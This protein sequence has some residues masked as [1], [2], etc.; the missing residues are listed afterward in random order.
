M[1]TTQMFK[2][3]SDY[4]FEDP[5]FNADFE[6]STISSGKEKY[7]L[8]K[9]VVST[10]QSLM[11]MDRDWWEDQ[12][13]KVVIVDEVHTASG[14]SIKSI[15][16]KLIHTKIRIGTTGTLQDAEVHEF[17]LT[18]LFGEPKQIIKTADLMET[19]Q[20]S[21]LNI[22]CLI[23]QYSKDTKNLARD[24][25]YQDEIDF[26]VSH[27][28]RNKFI[29]NLGLSLPGNTLILCNFVEKQTKV[30]YEMISS[31]LDPSSK[32]QV[33]IITGEISPE[34]REKIR[35]TVEKEGRDCIIVATMATL[36]TGINIISL[37]N[38]ILAHPSKAKIRLLQSI[39]RIL[40]RNESK[41]KTAAT[42]YDIADDLRGT[43]NYNFTMRHFAERL[44]IYINEHF[45]YKVKKI[46]LEE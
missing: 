26:I 44:K 9:F 31:K 27:P 3:F 34:E 17:V 12:D 45:E 43:K 19:K 33:F 6:I 16:E 2:D 37:H 25:E 36:S 38:L 29:A 20:V 41:G 1:L 28:R 10:Y 30:I 13:F 32:K 21:E 39:G 23:C 4:S 46:Q 8:N 40:R 42:L 5:D 22:K 11:N 35:N 15:M 24:F 14:A 18:G 7:R